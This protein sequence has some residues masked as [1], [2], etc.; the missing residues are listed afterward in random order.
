MEYTY[1]NYIIFRNVFAPSMPEIAGNIVG[2]GILAVFVELRSILL[3]VRWRKI[4]RRL[5][6][7]SHLQNPPRILFHSLFDGEDLD[8]VMSMELLGK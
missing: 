4:S 6:I 1:H 3:N 8:S 7:P 2:A 5:L